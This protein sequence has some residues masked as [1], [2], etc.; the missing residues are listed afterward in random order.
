MPSQDA[1]VVIA[2]N[3]GATLTLYYDPTS[4]AITKAVVDSTAARALI[5][6]K[7]LQDGAE[8]T[9][10]DVPPGITHTYQ[11]PANKFSL[12]QQTIDGNDVLVLP[13]GMSIQT[14][15]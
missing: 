11:L 5:H 8:L 4:L 14:W 13:P 1:T 12:V 6:Y 3:F 2:R 15:T 7:I 9:S 10:G